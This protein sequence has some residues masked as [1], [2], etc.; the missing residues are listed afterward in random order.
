VIEGKGQ[1]IRPQLSMPMGRIAIVVGLDEM[2]EYN[3]VVIILK[4]E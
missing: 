3:L 1:T 4:I 2:N